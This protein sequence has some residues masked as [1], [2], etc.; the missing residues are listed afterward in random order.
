M[1]GMACHAEE[2]ADESWRKFWK[3]GLTGVV[4][5]CLEIQEDYRLKMDK[6]QPDYDP[7]APR[8]DWETP[9][10]DIIRQLKELAK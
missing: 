5:D 3:P 1:C 9:V 7:E 10:D 4:N 6:A 8:G 2:R